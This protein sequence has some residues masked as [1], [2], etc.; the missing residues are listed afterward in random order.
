MLFYDFACLMLL[1][2]V[3]CMVAK[4]KEIKQH[5]DLTDKQKVSRTGV[6][7]VTDG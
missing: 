6:E 1:L 5:Q 2:T 4:L 3:C 7:P